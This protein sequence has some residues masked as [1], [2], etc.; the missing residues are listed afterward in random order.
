MI[1]NTTVEKGL[2]NLCCSNSTYNTDFNCFGY[3][4]WDFYNE[5]ISH[6]DLYSPIGDMLRLQN[7]D[8]NKKPAEK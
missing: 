2:A 5:V 8:V 7:Y 4:L 1:H 3:Y 6:K